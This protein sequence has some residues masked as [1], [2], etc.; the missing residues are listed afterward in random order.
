[1]NKTAP[2]LILALALTLWAADAPA[3][4]ERTLTDEPT[5]EK[6]QA[7]A[8]KDPAPA[9]KSAPA[10][11]PAP[12][13]K[14]AADGKSPFNS[15]APAVEKYP[16]PPASYGKGSGGAPGGTWT[17]GGQPPAAETP[18]EPPA[19][20]QG[21]GSRIFDMPEARQ[22]TTYSR[23][24]VDEQVMGFFEG[25]ARGLADLISRAFEKYGEPTG[26]IKGSEGA[27]ALVVG[28]RYGEGW[29]YLK[30]GQ[31]AYV[32]WQSP[33]VGLDLG[34]NASKVFCMVYGMTSVDQIY[35]RFPSVDGSAY[36]V[37]G[38][39]MNYQRSSPVVL[40]PIRFGVG[41]RLGANLG[42]MHFTKERTINPF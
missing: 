20:G 38:F 41:L 21:S 32:Y 12:E 36:V 27:G 25:G 19:S 6:P 22:V 14:P 34:V 5:V 2:L 29:L 26:F 28:F 10:P 42:Y 31:K 37:G 7:P 9:P 16:P 35:Q 18:A 33:S 39:G 30:N 3:L 24:E 13:A 4:Q 1:M 11:A 8:L 40:A 17:P 15:Q 23:K